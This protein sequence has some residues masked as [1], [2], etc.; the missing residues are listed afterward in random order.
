MIPKRVKFSIK[1]VSRM[2]IKFTD[3][4]CGPKSEAIQALQNEHNRTGDLPTL[5][6]LNMLLMD[7]GEWQRTKTNCTKIIEEEKYSNDGD[8]IT[9]GMAD[10]FMGDKTSAI[11]SWKQAVNAQY[12]DA[13]GPIDG[14]L[15][16]W[17]AGQRLGDEKL[18]KESLKK[19]KRFWKVQD[20]RVFSEWP[21][22]IAIA[23]FL[24]DEVPANVFLHE[25][26]WGNLEDRRICRA[27]FW[28]GMK[29]LEEGDET[30]AAAYFKSAFSGPK[31]AILEYEYFLAKR[32]FSR[33]TKQ[34]LWE[35]CLDR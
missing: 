33:L 23:G 29:C 21:G 27:N 32:E 8:Y 3:L 5:R 9:L 25:W 1:G 30:T 14:P 18:V 12:V 13:A 31:I 19:L 35:N 28:L 2:T 6:N 22:T 34:N 15:I 16:L 7:I 20:Y 24:L 26:K 10:W 11:D 4:L 17:Y